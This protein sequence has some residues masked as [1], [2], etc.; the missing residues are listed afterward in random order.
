[1]KIDTRNNRDLCRLIVTALH[2]LGYTW[3][4]NIANGR[5]YLLTDTFG[6]IIG[7][8]AALQEER[9]EPPFNELEHELVTVEE[10]L[11]MTEQESK[12]GMEI[13][14]SC[15]KRTGSQWKNFYYKLHDAL[16]FH[17]IDVD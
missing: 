2:D 10:L 6:N 5:R 7:T 8:D 14:G 3:F 12:F 4:K 15:V 13:D 17:G 11:A 1:M 16:A 9:G